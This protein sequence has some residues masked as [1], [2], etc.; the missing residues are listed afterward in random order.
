MANHRL[1]LDEP[2]EGQVGKSTKYK[3]DDGVLEINWQGERTW[4]YFQPKTAVLVMCDG[5]LPD[6]VP[7]IIPK[8]FRWRSLWLCGV[9]KKGRCGSRAEFNARI[10]E[11]KPHRIKEGRA[12]KI[13]W[14]LGRDGKEEIYLGWISGKVN[15]SDVREMVEACDVTAPGWFVQ[16]VL[17][18]EEVQP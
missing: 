15:N 14:K 8:N 5:T 2:S 17:G 18:F 7:M 16:E 6:V 13:A 9:P 4:F 3:Y 1:Y 10:L 12:W 11:E